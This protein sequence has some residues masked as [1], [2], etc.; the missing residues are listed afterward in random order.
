MAGRLLAIGDIH[1]CLAQFD[2]LIGAIDICPSDHLILLGDYVDRGPNSAGVLSRIIELSWRQKVTALMGNHEELMLAA[3]K[4]DDDLAIWMQFG[5]KTAIKSYS[6]G[7]LQDVP[8]EHWAFLEKL[9]PY[10]ETE[11]HVFVHAGIVSNLA[12]ELQPQEIRLWQ[13]FNRMGRHA[14]GKTIVCGHTIQSSGQPGSRGYAVCIDTGAGSEGP[15]TCLDV[16][17]GE[18][19]Q[20]NDSGSVTRNKLRM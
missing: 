15:L 7:T 1:G 9:M 6:G 5:G 2:A 19:W 10:M 4:S 13:T 17:S 14:G 8:S 3:R 12:M 11:S 20:A 18:F 16:N